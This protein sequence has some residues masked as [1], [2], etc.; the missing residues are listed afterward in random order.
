VAPAGFS[1]I[2]PKS[3]L[4]QFKPI[5]PCFVL[6][7][8]REQLV[9]SCLWR[10]GEL[11]ALLDLPPQ[12]GVFRILLS[13]SRWRLQWEQHPSGLILVGCREYRGECSKCWGATG[14]GVVPGGPG[15]QACDQSCVIE[16]WVWLSS[17]VSHRRVCYG[18]PSFRDGMES[19]LSTLG[20][21]LRFEKTTFLFGVP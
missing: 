7:G 9:P 10:Q 1:S 5:F 18:M 12:G 13:R 15:R 4:L 14:K 16:N 8:S 6:S 17:Q 20:H 2:W 11:G 19:V 3:P 21:R